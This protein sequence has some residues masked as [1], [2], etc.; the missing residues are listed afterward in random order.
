MLT[1]W[2]PRQPAFCDGRSRRSFL[3]AGALGLSG[4]S[5]ADLLRAQA[6]GA[7]SGPLFAKSV[8]LVILPGGPSH[9]DMYDPKPEA[10]AEVRGPFRSIATSVPGVQWSELMPMQ[11]KIADKLALVRGLKTQAKEHYYH[12]VVTGYPPRLNGIVAL[13]S[14]RPSFGSVVSRLRGPGRDELPAYVSLR[15]AAAFGNLKDVEGPAFLGA[16][17]APFVPQGRG[18]ENL[19]LAAGVTPERLE[20][21]RG[22]LHEIDGFRRQVDAKGALDGLDEFGRRAFEMLAS[23]RVRDAFDVGR[24][25]EAVRAQYGPKGQYTY[26]G[27][28]MPW[29]PAVFLQ[30]RRLVE[31]GVPVVTLSVGSWDHHSPKDGIFSDLRTIVP[32]LDHAI[33]GLVTD[34]HDRGLDRDVAVVVWGEMGRTPKINATKGGGRDHWPDAGCAVIAAGGLR[35]GQVIGATD[36]VGAR[37]TGVAYTPQNVFATLYHLIGIDPSQTLPDRTGRPLTLLDDQEMIEPLL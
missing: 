3:R 20:G 23:S 6:R 24:E 5:L 16:G 30:A 18:V 35:M 11:A 31:S 13:P 9:I 27:S 8:I 21:R 2:G 25:P 28:K 7:A 14:E 33:H 19:K 10:P 36:R 29:D 26:Y 22:L 34:L 15:A 4:L 37:A 32:L 1:V 12:E 17:H